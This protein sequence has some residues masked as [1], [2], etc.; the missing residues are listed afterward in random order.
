MAVASLSVTSHVTQSTSRG[1]M[2]SDLRVKQCNQFSVRDDRQFSGVIDQ[3]NYMTIISYR[4]IVF[5]KT[6]KEK[7]ND[8]NEI[9]V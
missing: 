5:I 6:Y 8:S 1:E 2:C 4:R 3:I 9:H 7:Y